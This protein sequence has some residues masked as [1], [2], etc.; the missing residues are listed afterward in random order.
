MQK[1]EKNKI[2]GSNNKKIWK[3][4]KTI[5]IFPFWLI[6]TLFLFFYHILNILLIIFAVGVFA[7]V[8]IFTKVYP[9]YQEASSS[10]YEKLSKLEDSNFRMLE[11]TVIYD[12][13]DKIIGKI[14]TGNYQYVKI[15][16]IS[17]YIQKGYIAI[18]DKRFMQHIGIDA[19]SLVRAGISLFRHNGEITQGGSTIT[20]Q[21]IKNNLLTQEQSFSRKLVEIL[22]APK[23]EQ[24][25]SKAD[26]MEFY[27]NTNYYGNGCYGIETASQFYFGKSCEELTLGEAA[28]L[29]GVSNSPNNYNPIASMELATQKK[30]QVLNAMRKEGYITEKEYEKAQKQK[31]KVKSMVDEYDND[32]YMIS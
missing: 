29:C 13:N 16:Q 5:I 12:K 22:I 26:I 15:N 17:D 28:M 3:W 24:K 1:E 18:E 21:V 8:V 14:D 4:I 32:N 2:K 10:A 11:D 23:I 31:I 20:Q 6:E 19:Q 30:T 9:M 25:Y 27:V 7:G